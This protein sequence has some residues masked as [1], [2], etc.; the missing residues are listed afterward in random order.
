M[1]FRLLNTAGAALGALGLSGVRLD[2]DALLR[3]AS[4]RTGLTDFGDPGFLG[5]IR[6]LLGSIERDANLHFVG[7]LG[8]R[9]VV[10]DGLVNRL[11]LTE[12]QKRVPERFAEP[13]IPPL[14]VMG[15]PRSGTTFLHRLLAEDPANYAS[16]YWELARPL[17]PPGKP[18]TRRRDGA[19]VLRAGKYLMGDLDRKHFTAVD[20]PEEDVIMLGAT[21]ESW[22]FWSN[23]SVY[24]YLEWYLSQDH[25]RKYREYRAWLQVLQ[26]AHPGRR[27]VL[28]APE[29]TGGLS[30][31]LQAVPE[32][33]PLQMLRDPLTAFASYVSLTRTGQGMLADAVDA[34]RNAAT[35]L[36][37]LAE[38]ANRNL[39]ARDAN[40]G[41]VLDV[42]YDDLVADPAGVV[43][44][45][46]GH[47]G[48]ALTDAA[49]G[50]VDRYAKENPRG[51]HGVHRYTVGDTGL[52]EDAVRARFA[53]YNERFGFA[54]SRGPSDR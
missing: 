45:I 38:E 1:P 10:L 46:Y 41:A 8:L 53:A 19:R 32:A 3:D 17:P 42:H 14:V 47:H 54:T 36:H 2:E 33:R 40:P 11:L 20:T 24:G 49:R 25:A 9:R 44:R 31:L 52:G 37:L 34:T 16:P 13:L 26:A 35:N 22:F 18:D 43:R 12:A 50:A 4:R 48:L 15:L 7:R 6:A 5:G 51:K 27:L 29:H 28:K 23:A 21:F 30:A 39:A